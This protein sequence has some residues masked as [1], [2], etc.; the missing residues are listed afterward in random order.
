[1]RKRFLILVG[2]SL[3]FV[4]AMVF[5]AMAVDSEKITLPKPA[6][7]KSK[8]LFQVLKERNSSREFSGEELPAQLLSNLLWAA[9]GINRS[10]S[11]KRTAPTSYNKQ[12]IDIYVSMK[13]GAFLYNPKDHSLQKIVSEDIREATG[14]QN[15][16]R[17]AALNLVYVADLTRMG[18]GDE[19]TKLITAACDT[20]FIGQ[21]VYLFCASEGL[22]TVFRA[23]IDKEKLSEV[24]KL[25]PDQ[26]I[27]YS[28]TV[29]FPKG[30]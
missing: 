3:M 10:D 11:G 19:T 2:T 16:V 21:N 18:E 13:N 27:T 1:M 5:S 23:S 30:K 28:Q 8:P 7:D 15:F 12:E 26:K 17:D 9:S 22:A 20:G 25:R 14:K 6:F 29:G 4:A 24:L